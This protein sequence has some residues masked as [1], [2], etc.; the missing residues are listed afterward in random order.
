MIL[1]VDKVFE[2]IRNLTVRYISQETLFPSE[3]SQYDRWV[4]REALHNCIA[5]QDYRR[6][7]RITVTERPDSLMF[8]NRGDFIPG[9]VRSV[10]ERDVPPDL[11]RNPFL[12]NAMVELNMIDTIGSGIKRMFTKQRDRYFPM[13][14]YNL[15]EEGVVRVTIPGRVIDE[16]YTLMLIKLTD[17]TLTDV[18]ALDKVQKGKPLS[19]QERDSLRGKRLIEGR[20]PNLY[21]SEYVA[22]ETDT[23]ADYIRKRSFDRQHF[24]DMI[25]A[26]LERFGEAK[27]KD[28]DGLLMEKVS[29]VLNATQKRQYI[30]DLLREMREEGLIETTGKTRGATWILSK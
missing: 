18:I 20:H 16:K 14:D 15:D 21:V 29:D 30:K 25:I 7:A 23:R 19:Q 27:R 22:A 2:K 28:I 13:P 3:I 12:A 24:K 26:Y 6:S 5:H 11:Y 17:L 4:I 8:T 9:S 10:I 1:A